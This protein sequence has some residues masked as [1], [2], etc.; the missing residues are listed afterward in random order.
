MLPPRAVPDGKTDEDERVMNPDEIDGTFRLPMLST[1][2]AVMKL[3]EEVEVDVPVGEPGAEV[4]VFI[5]DVQVSV[6]AVDTAVPA[7]V[8]TSVGVAVELEELQPLL[9]SVGE[10]SVALDD[11]LEEDDPESDP[12]P[13]E[14]ESA[15]TQVIPVIRPTL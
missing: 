2:P 11:E 10:E 13:E 15:Q 5:A 8:S 6:D 3:V 7:A 12:E 9:E 14:S 1:A 4:Q